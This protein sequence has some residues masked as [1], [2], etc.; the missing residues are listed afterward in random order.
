MLIYIF[1]YFMVFTFIAFSRTILAENSGVSKVLSH[2]FYF[3]SS[4]FLF[5]ISALR[6]EVGTDFFGYYNF[7]NGVSIQDI[8]NFEILYNLL[9]IISKSILNNGQF[10]IAVI[11]F[12]T[13]FNISYSIYKLSPYAE[14]SLIIFF[15]LG[16]YFNTFN[17]VRQYL[18]ISLIILAIS[19]WYNEKKRLG[20]LMLIPPILIHFSS[21]IFVVIF[22]MLNLIKENKIIYTFFMLLIILSSLVLYM[23]PSLF[24][25][26]IFIRDYR[27]YLE[28][29]FV[30]VGAN[31]IWV[32]LE[33]IILLFYAFFNHKSKVFHQRNNLLDLA[34]PF[35]LL[36][37]IFSFF[38]LRGMLF[39]RL[40]LY[41]NIFHIFFIPLTIKNIQDSFTRRLVYLIIVIVAFFGMMLFLERGLAG[42]VPYKTFLSK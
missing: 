6:Y 15:G 35:S 39:N 8:K 9:A 12:L 2:Y 40:A 21:L 28:S 32:I 30:K 3:I 33:V 41:F 7:I 17:V 38:G 23:K 27:F 37:I 22:I 11:A 1:E 19:F 18:A 29:E 13:I 5:L 34:V 4:T 16:Y 42:V 25:D 31:F 24:Y 20:L 10:F 26:F 14:I 36:S